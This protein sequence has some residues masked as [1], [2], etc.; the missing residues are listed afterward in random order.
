[1]RSYFNGVLSFIGAESLTDEE[2][3]SIELEDTVDLVANYN[4]LL[5]ILQ[6]RE[7]VTALTDKL[8][9]YYLALGADVSDPVNPVSQ[10]F[11]GASLDDE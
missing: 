7:A 2:F 10:I 8:Q 9:F 6:A 4:T 1:M 11:V 5:V 3:E